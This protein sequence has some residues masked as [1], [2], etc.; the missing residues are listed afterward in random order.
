[1]DTQILKLLLFLWGMNLA[2]TQSQ[3]AKQPNLTPEF[4]SHWYSGTALVSTYDLKQVRYGEIHQG[5]AA[6]ILVTEPF[7]K[8]KLIK[9]DDPDQNPN[10]KISTFKCNF[11]KKFFTGIYPYSMM[12]SSFHPL[13]KMDRTLKVTCSAQEW[14]GQTFAQLKAVS[15]GYRFRLYSYFEREGEKDE[16]IKGDVWIEDAI[17]QLIKINPQELPQGDILMIPGLMFSRLRHH[18]SMTVPVNAR[19]SQ[20]SEAQ[21]QY[22]LEYPSLNRTLSIF[23][24]KDFP[25]QITGWDESHP[26]GFGS[27][28]TVLATKATL[29][30]ELMLDYWNHNEVQDSVYRHLL[31]NPVESP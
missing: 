2:C 1:M 7:S 22:T 9:L 3:I 10:D 14:C 25:Y 20:K 31:D 13:E 17:W 15:S 23:F 29:K 24:K 16:K 28:A 18:P 19:L 11:T 30:N 4:K 6:I 27:E 5:E 12:M 21:Y 8:S 26:S